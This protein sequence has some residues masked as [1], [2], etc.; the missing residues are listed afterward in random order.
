MTYSFA[1]PKYLSKL[2]TL[3]CQTYHKAEW[4]DELKDAR[5]SLVS[6]SRPFSPDFSADEDILDAN[7]FLEGNQLFDLGHEKQRCTFRAS[8]DNHSANP[9]KGDSQSQFS[10]GKIEIY[11]GK[12]LGK[13]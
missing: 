12:I 1:L 3:K 2:Q 4:D 6:Y 10:P 8:Q 13:N 7:F 9:N 5:E 11:F